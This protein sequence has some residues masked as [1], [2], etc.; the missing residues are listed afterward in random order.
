MP[1]QKKQRN[2]DWKSRAK[3]MRSNFRDDFS[4]AN[5][6]QYYVGDPAPTPTDAPGGHGDRAQLARKLAKRGD[7]RNQQLYDL[8]QKT[9]TLYRPGEGPDTKLGGPGGPE[10]TPTGAMPG[11]PPDPGLPGTGTGMPAASSPQSASGYSTTQTPGGVLYN[12][13]NGSFPNTIAA[14]MSMQDPNNPIGALQNL[15]RPR[16]ATGSELDGIS[17]MPTSNPFDFSGAPYAPPAAPSSAPSTA[18]PMAYG[19]MYSPG[20]GQGKGRRRRPR[21]P[22]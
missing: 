10:P 6:T 22:V 1:Q 18:P 15:V 8:V 12:T 4:N 14:F 21:R 7:M 19:A 3:E 11:V 9:G 20:P 13:P 2:E 5:R 17:P 16:P